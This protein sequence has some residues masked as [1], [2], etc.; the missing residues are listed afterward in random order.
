MQNNQ[1]FIIRRVVTQSPLPSSIQER[2]TFA[3]DCLK[4]ACKDISEPVTVLQTPGGFLFNCQDL[5]T[6][7]TGINSTVSHFDFVVDK[8]EQFMHIFLSG[9]FVQ[10]IS[11]KTDFVTFGIDIFHHVSTDICDYNRSRKRKQSEKH[12][13]LVGT[14]DTKHQKFTG[15]TGKSYPV[16]FQEK[17]LLYCCE[18]GSHFQY[19]GQT[20]VLVL[21]C[22][23][24]NI[25]SPRSRKSSRTGT[26]KGNLISVMQKRCDEFKP[27]VVLHHPHSTDSSRI[28]S[29]AW[30]GVQKF[31]PSVKIFSSG[32]HYENVNVGVQRQPLDRVLTATA[33]GNI[34]N[35]VI[36]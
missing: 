13:E 10:M 27:Q 2:I 1:P 7:Q 16:H 18:L 33:L 4:K 28:W 32:I 25:F 24:L 3:T 36:Y 30:S 6:I 14:F 23:D 9:D 5:G 26:Y 20:P 11:L 34:V 35:T 21:G 17:T 12:V 29:T 8:V 31:I 19:F 22:H 15:W